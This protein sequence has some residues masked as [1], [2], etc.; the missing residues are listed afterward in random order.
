VQVTR[1]ILWLAALSRLA[2]GYAQ[3]AAGQAV[4]LRND[5]GDALKTPGSLQSRLRFEH[6]TSAEGLSNDSVFAILQ[7]HRGFMWFGTQGGL[8]RYDG[9]RIT[10]Y[11]HDPGNPKSLA[12]DFVDTLFED[13]RGGIWTGLSR[14]D[15]ETETFTHYTLPSESSSPGQGK[16]TVRE[17]ERGFLWMGC[18]GRGHLYRFDPRTGIFRGYDLGMDTARA[19]PNSGVESMYFD[20]SGILW[21]GTTDGLVRFDPSTE[22][23]LLYRPSFSTANSFA[24]GIRGIVA[25]RAG[26]LWLAT[27]EGTENVF[28]PVTRTF[29]RNWSEAVR[30]G[31]DMNQTIFAD[32]GGRIW[33]G[34]RD[35]LKVFDPETGALA[36]LRNDPADSYSISGNEV[37]SIVN[38]REGNLW[39][40]VKGGGVNRLSPR[41]TAFG[42]WRRKPGDPGGLSD[43][44]VR[45]IYGDHTGSVW[46]GTYD[47]GLDRFEPASGKFVHYRHDPQYPRSLDSDRV[48]SIYEDRSGT[49]W[50]GTDR[51]INRLDRESGTF[52][53]FS[54][55]SIITV[56]AAPVYFFHE[57]RAGRFWF[58]LSGGGRG[59]L[60]RSTG[61]VTRG[62]DS[63][64]SMEEDRK[65]N[66][67][68][69]SSAGLSKV[70]L[71]GK[72]RTIPVP[73]SLGDSGQR[74]PHINFFHEDSE[75]LLWLATETGLLRFD[76]Q[77]EKYTSYT[78]RNGLPDNVVQ[79]ILADQTGNLWLSTNN[80]ISIFNPRE[81]NFHNYHE[82]DGLQG[83][84]FNRK[85]CYQDSAGRMYFGGIHGFNAFDPT[86]IPSS[87][88]AQPLVFT[89][90]Q[91]HGKTVPV[92]PGSV[93]ARPIWEMDKI[94]LSYQENGFS[95]EFAALSYVSPA[96]TRYRF[97][98]EG[99]EAQWTEVDSRHRYARYTD[100]RPGDYTFRVQASTDGRM[101]SEK[102]AS[103]G[104]AIVPPW[105]MT[106][107]S[108]GGFIVA[109]ICLILGTH[110]WRLKGLRERELRLQTVVEQRTAELTEARDQA[111][112]ANRAKSAF[113]ASMSHELRTP[114]NAIMGF[115]S[116]LREGG[117]SF[118]ERCKDLD[119]INRSGEHLLGLID[120]VLDVAKIE[121]GR[122]TAENAPCNVHSLMHDIVEMMRVRAREKNLKLIVEES[123]HF[124]RFVR[125]DAP[126]LRQIL[127]NLL[128]NAVKYTE[129]GIIILR[130]VSLP[131]DSSNRLRLRFDVEDSGIGIAPEDQARVFEPFVRAGRLS[132]QDGTGLG[133]AIVRQYV[134]MLGGT[135]TLESELGKGARFRLELP[136]AQEAESGVTAA[137]DSRPRA[138]RIEPGQPEY[139]VLIVEDQVENRLLLRRL[140]ERV[141][142]QVRVAEDGAVGIEVFQ[143]WRPHFIWMDRGL[144]EIDGSETVRRIR[145]LEGGREV[146][147]AAVTASVL[148]AQRAEMMAAGVDEFLSKPYRLEEILDCMARHL[149]VRYARAERPL[150]PLVQAKAHLRPEA[151]AGLPEE[152]RQELTKAVMALDK[153][154]IAELVRRISEIDPALGDVLAVLSANFSYTL[155]L[156]ALR[157]TNGPSAAAAA[158]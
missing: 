27:S 130:L 101:W 121:A 31:A 68:F 114:L 26:K 109:L 147:I 67:W 138:V 44:N 76:P 96:R 6:L 108:Q 77:T 16:M 84:T 120:N 71:A 113:L 104:I 123:P 145:A 13:K 93:L 117:E 136:V 35:G 116:L 36:I 92:R 149:G 11:R 152:L 5:L 66:L 53:H 110:R 70:D 47:G 91:I 112:T 59:L 61:T 85:A 129:R 32:P 25:D 20:A 98:L 48:Y 97:R 146:K 14:F 51:G 7:D 125:T 86:Q 39:V 154:R 106:R 60:D 69:V 148:A 64:L 134:E 10:Q 28:D 75:G 140:L 111:Q 95:L 158:E 45:A 131:E 55:D 88:P 72:V 133:L 128:G 143:S 144:G 52:E 80:G 141:G 15:P 40:G 54:R 58:G 87:Q 127:I 19:G 56:E 2:P 57:D 151:L 4:E 42:A 3:N 99:L 81:N 21:L 119:I 9:Y 12:D 22:V 73:S 49:L 50:V 103:L 74:S 137:L 29:A 82:S 1:I 17:D 115:S 89:E 30:P 102:G 34:T 118:E 135:I 90:F 124:P 107:W 41:S 23:S 132:A 78:T 38:D 43:N 139:R 155:I 153:E 46:I 126:K 83:E 94:K 100:L 150:Q 157:G 142:F 33:M 105:W 122:I 24:R 156:K 65:G 79:C 62:G 18:I 8:N 37:W 63:S